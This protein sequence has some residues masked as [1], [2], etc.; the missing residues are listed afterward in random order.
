M[1]Y[2]NDRPFLV[3]IMAL[4]CIFMIALYNRAYP[5]NNDFNRKVFL[6]TYIILFL[7]FILDFIYNLRRIL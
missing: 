4:L 6:I 5:V 2:I 7:F 3:A 1:E